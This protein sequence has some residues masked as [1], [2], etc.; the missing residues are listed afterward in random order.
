[1]SDKKVI[2]DEK[3]VS[4][5]ELDKIKKNPNKK[6]KKLSENKY[7]ILQKLEG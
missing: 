4:L 1:M 6:L 7:K 3:E 2:V 5:E